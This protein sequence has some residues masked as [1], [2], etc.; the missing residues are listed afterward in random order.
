MPDYTF[1]TSLYTSLTKAFAKYGWTSATEQLAPLGTTDFT[2]YLLNIANSGAD[3]MFNETVGADEVTSTK[4]AV[5]F[6]IMKKMKYVIPLLSPFIE[7]PMGPEVLGGMYGTLPW[8]LGHAGEISA[9]KIFRRGF[10]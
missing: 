2:S 3:V 9:G 1:G 6:G 5:Q 10:P 8:Y 7:K 4:Q